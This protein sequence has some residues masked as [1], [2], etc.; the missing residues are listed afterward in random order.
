MKNLNKHAPYN[1]NPGKVDLAWD[2]YVNCG[3]LPKNSIRKIVS[4]SWARCL[5]DGVDPSSSKTRLSVNDKTY[6]IL[7][8]DNAQLVEAAKPVMEHARNL[9]AG[10]GSMMIL[11]DKNGICLHVE[12]DRKTVED[13]HDI[14][15]AVRANWSERAA[16]T[17]AI[18]TVLSVG[19]PIQINT[20]EH[21]CEGIKSWTCTAM[22]IRDPRSQE[23]IGALDLSGLT[24]DFSYHTQALVVE[25]AGRIE[26]RLVGIRLEEKNRLLNAAV[27]IHKRGYNFLKLQIYASPKYCELQ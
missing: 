12:G 14:Q 7:L 13:G 2:R 10:S 15:L 6:K 21:F 8:K 20:S 9:L 25:A 5:E 23:I 27:S 26:S 18:G 4:D 11:A 16:G 3:E 22:V 17:N 24:S 19:M 1:I